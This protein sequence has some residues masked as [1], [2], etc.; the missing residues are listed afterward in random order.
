MRGGGQSGQGQREKPLSIMPYICGAD[1]SK[2]MSRVDIYLLPPV[3][4]I[5][6]QEVHHQSINNQFICTYCEEELIH[7]S[8]N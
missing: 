8:S 6:D 5:C 2:A 7:A 4:E 3:C 1:G